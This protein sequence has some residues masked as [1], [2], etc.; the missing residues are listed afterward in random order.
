MDDI[1]SLFSIDICLVYVL[2]SLKFVLFA[3]QLFYSG[4]ELNC[5]KLHMILLFGLFLNLGT[6]HSNLFHVFSNINAVA[7]INEAVGKISSQRVFPFRVE[8]TCL[9]ELLFQML[10]FLFHSNQLLAEFLL[11]IVCLLYTSPSP[12][13]KRQSRMPSSA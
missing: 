7:M 2:I 10:Y 9:C 6:Q 1:T 12:R 3:L 4:L 11:L 8:I 5:L 13:D